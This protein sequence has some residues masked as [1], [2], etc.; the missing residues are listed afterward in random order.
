[1]G[2]SRALLKW[3]DHEKSHLAVAFFIKQRLITSSRLQQA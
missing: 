1:M 3:G 2:L